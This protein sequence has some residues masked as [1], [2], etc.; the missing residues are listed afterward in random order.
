MKFACARREE[1]NKGVVCDEVDEGCSDD[2][3]GCRG[4]PL[5]ERRTAGLMRDYA[6]G[7]R[8]VS[9]EDPECMLKIVEQNEVQVVCP[10][11]DWCGEVM[12]MFAYVRRQDER[13]SQSCTCTR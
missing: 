13:V 6:R 11:T 2:F 9:G 4:A 8:D 5:G 3:Q 7:E 10:C 1:S 12:Y